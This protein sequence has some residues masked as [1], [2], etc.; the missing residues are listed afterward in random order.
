M[1]GFL[2]TGLPAADEALG[3]GWKV[4]ALLELIGEENSGKRT[5]A[6]SACAKLDEEALWLELG[7]RFDQA[8]ARVCGWSKQSM[9]YVPGYNAL[10]NVTQH[11]R[12]GNSRLVVVSTATKVGIGDPLWFSSGQVER[13]M[14]KLCEVA[15]SHGVA[16]LFV[17]DCHAAR[18]GEEGAAASVRGAVRYYSGQR[19]RVVSHPWADGGK[20]GVFGQGQVLKNKFAMPFARFVFSVQHSCGLAA[21]P[22]AGAAAAA[23]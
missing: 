18:R 4:G 20:R 10:D 5:L 15:Y 19:V 6:Y 23:R 21:A 16:V 9:I 14:R 13:Q 22:Q 1:N 8:Y 11:V 7:G 17:T 3:G 2:N 12:S